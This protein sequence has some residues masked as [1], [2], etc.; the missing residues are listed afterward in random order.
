MVFISLNFYIFILFALIL[1]YVFPKKY[2]WI[3]LFLSNIAFYYAFFKDGWIVL[4][5]TIVVNYATG[6]ILEKVKA[7]SEGNSN[8][9]RIVLILGI[10]LCV[11]PWL[12]LKYIG[13]EKTPLFIVPIGISFYT[14]TSIAYIVDVYRGKIEAQKNIFK[15]ALFI[16]FFPHLLQ[17][18]IPRYEEL[19]GQLFCGN[20][21]DEK[22]I[23]KGVYLIIWGF[24]LKLLIADKAAVIVNTVFDNYTTYTGVYVWLASVLYSIQLYADFLA[25]TTLAQGVA[26]LFG[27]SLTD[28][29]ARPYLA[30][31]IGDFWRRWHI[32]LS[33]WLKDYIYIPLG[34]NRKGKIRKYLNL[35]LTFIVSGIWHG[36]GMKF[37]FWGLMHGCY[38][39]IG[40]LTT[41]VREKVYVFLHVSED[42]SFKRRLKI[43]GT[44]IA[45]N[46][47]WIIF[48]A[49]SLKIG[50]SM[51]VNATK[52]NPWVLFDDSIYK[53]GLPWKQVIVLAIAIAV[54]IFIS[55]RQ[56]RGEIITSTIMQKNIV[57]RW[58]LIILAVLVI[59]IFGTYG[60]GYDAQNFIYGGF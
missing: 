20:L 37:V 10:M 42:S 59:V 1:Y 58:C 27:V 55:L 45:V 4:I 60:Y 34:G 41:G 40:A 6:V 46:T 48:R 5:M 33:L 44:F 56:E 16:S 9:S 24:F 2:R 53:L 15:Y 38:Q 7:S 32:S 18:P 39:V 31:S 28:N 22:K 52:L 29:F 47:A 36:V 30:T 21:F 12:F 3:V 23:T 54:M 43:F 35:I 13:L 57:V 19:G 8:R 17:G 11:M 14:M 51:I 50:I 25:C 26:L 49:D